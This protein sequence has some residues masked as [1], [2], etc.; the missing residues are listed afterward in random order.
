MS[1]NPFQKALPVWG[2]N[3]TEPNQYV[4]FRETFVLSALP[5]TAFLRIRVE[6]RYSATLNGRWLPA[7]QYADFTEH[8]VYEEVPLDSAWFVLG[9]NRFSLL[10]YCQNEDSLTYRRGEP[11]AQYELLC[12][13]AVVAASGAQTMCTDQTGFVSGAGVEKLT[14][15]LSYSFRYDEAAGERGA[16]AY[17]PAVVLPQNPAA[18]RLRPIPPLQ[19]GAPQTATVVAQGTFGQADEEQSGMRMYRASLRHVPF[20]E[21]AAGKNRTLPAEEGIV[22]SAR[23][24]DGIFVVLDLGRESVGYLTLDVETDVACRV[25]GGIGEHLEDLRVRTYVGHRNFAFSIEKKA[26]RLRLEWPIKRFGCRYLQLHI[27]T[28]RVTLYSASLRPTNYPVQADRMP[29][30]LNSLQQRIYQIAVETLKCCMHEHYEDCPWR[31]QA[32]YAMDSRNQMLFGYLAFGE[33]AMPRESLR[34]LS[35]GQRKEGVLELTSPGHTGTGACIPSFSLIWVL[36][37]Q[38]YVRETGDVAFAREM[39]P[40]MQGIFS[41][42]DEW[43]QGALV[44]LPVGYWNFYEWAPNLDGHGSAECKA[45]REGKADAP[46]NCFYALALRAAASL[47]QS[48]GHTEQ[49]AAYLSRLSALKEQFRRSFYSEE[50]RAFCLGHG[51]A[52]DDACFPELVQSLAVLAELFENEEQEASVCR[53][54]LD[55]EF[56][57]TVTLSHRAFFYQALLRFPH[58]RDEVLADVEKHWAPMVY[59]GTTTFWETEDGACAFH[60]AG[61]L[62]HGWSAAP[63]YVYH[64]LFSGADEGTA[65]ATDARI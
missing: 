5:K 52:G 30:G 39:E 38:E 19:V 2:Q 11:S 58:L 33:T 48:M 37:L 9:E 61:S 27:A 18:Y 4:A 41:F 55:G 59:A 16:Q 1:K 47:E 23:E 54:L 57:P 34:L 24:D 28:D 56:S 8:P 35:Q 31:E 21:L 44:C 3:R 14:G 26:G 46:L 17:A 12:D 62:C 65:S 42:F 29:Q 6:N 32:L 20:D 22:F 7:Q 50:H 63:I 40:A 60:D 15:Q 43:R 10:G 36:A 49:S 45:A 64:R 51:A 53:R 25:D 13:G